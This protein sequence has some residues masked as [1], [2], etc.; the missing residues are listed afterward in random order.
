LKGCFLIFNYVACVL[1]HFSFEIV[2]NIF[3]TFTVLYYALYYEHSI[4]MHS[5]I[6]ILYTNA[7]IDEVIH[8][9]HC[10]V[11]RGTTFHKKLNNYTCNKYRD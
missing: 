10:D 9:I 2:N 3:Y 8:S 4:A 5:S 1:D 11:L 6:V 7:T